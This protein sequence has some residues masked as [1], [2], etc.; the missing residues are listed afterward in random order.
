[1]HGRCGWLRIVAAGA[2]AMTIVKTLA[3]YALVNLPL[4]VCYFLRV[5][6]KGDLTG[7]LL[8]IMHVFVG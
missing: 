4:F 7:R 5:F 2:D 3:K 1:M 8:R 6:L